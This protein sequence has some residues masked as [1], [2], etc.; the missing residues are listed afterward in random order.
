MGFKAFKNHIGSLASTVVADIAGNFMQQGNQKD[1]GKVSA[2]LLKKGPFDIPNSPSQKL[3]EN[4]L[5]FSAVQYPIDL[6]TA[7]LGHYIMFEAGFLRYQPQQDNMFVTSSTTK[8]G[9]KTQ[10]A[11][12]TSKIPVGSISNSAIAIYMPPNVKVGYNQSYDNDSETYVQFHAFHNDEEMKRER[13]EQR[14]SVF[15]TV[16]GKNGLFT[17]DYLVTNDRQKAIQF[18]LESA[19][20]LIDNTGK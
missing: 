16:N 3:R 1:A 17:D 7:E 5:S 10:Q 11:K 19:I 12:V 2:Q 6:G 8:P 20:V 15:S 14:Y 4:P 9:S 13:I 18:A